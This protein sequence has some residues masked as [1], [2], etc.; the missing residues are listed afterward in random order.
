MSSSENIQ[1]ALRFR[2]LNQ[3]E[4]NDHEE[5]VWSTS[6]HTVYLKPEFQDRLQAEKRITNSMRSYTY[7]QVFTEKHSNEKV[8]QNAVKRVVM[9]SLEGYNGTIFAYG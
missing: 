7:N 5:K 1:V 3:R 6:T 4:L 2:P 8:Y 9:S